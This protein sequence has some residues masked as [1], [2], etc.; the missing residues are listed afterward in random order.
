M[1]NDRKR[2]GSFARKALPTVE[3]MRHLIVA[4][5]KVYRTV[6]SPLLPFNQCRFVPSC[7]EYMIEAVEKHGATKGS[8]LGLKR[9]LRCHPYH[10][11]DVYDPVPEPGTH[12]KG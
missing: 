6:I 5:L 2:P 1:Q 12:Q 3:F 4:I 11:H 9:L 7:S 10:R 8:I